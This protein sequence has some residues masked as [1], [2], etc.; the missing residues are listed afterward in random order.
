HAKEN[1][2]QHVL[3]VTIHVS[4]GA[5]HRLGAIRLEG[6]KTINERYVRKRLL[7]HTGEEYRASAVENARKDLLGVGVFTQVSVSLAPMPDE[8]GG[9]P[10]TFRFVERKPRTVG[11]TAAYSSDLGTSVGVNWLK[12]E[13]TGNA[14][15]L[16][17]SADV[18]NL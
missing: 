14:D 9:V 6:L 15:P 2:S 13:I 3:N 5:R 16:T 8:T 10:V 18:I 17:L 7:I 12:R 1:S 4:P 11:V